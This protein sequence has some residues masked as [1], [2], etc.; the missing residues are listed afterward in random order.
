MTTA[1]ATSFADPTRARL[2]ALLSTGIPPGAAARAVGVT[3]SYVSQLLAEDESFAEAV[4]VAR[5]KTLEEDVS[6]DNTVKSVE[7]KSL[8]LISDRLGQVKSAMDAARI[9]QI[10]NNS[11]RRTE[12]A[13][14]DKL[15]NTPTVSVTLNIPA[16]A[17]SLVTARNSQGEIIEIGGRSLATAPASK[18]AD[19]RSKLAE[20]EQERV[21]LRLDQVRALAVGD[22]K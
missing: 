10:L 1:L 21:R 7:A 16:A 6:H 20:R 9:F 17:A 11:K 5:V 18:I 3:P 14:V 13:A 15:D 19:I 8:K 22:F 12:E 4:A 2:F